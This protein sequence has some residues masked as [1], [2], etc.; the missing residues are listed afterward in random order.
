MPDGRIFH[1]ITRGSGMM[2]AYAGQISPDDRWK[3]V[4]YVRALQAGAQ[5]RRG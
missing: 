4:L 3:A 5:G 2:P 1:V